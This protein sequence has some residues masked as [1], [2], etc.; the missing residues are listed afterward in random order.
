MI[1]K[2]QFFKNVDNLPKLI[3]SGKQHKKYIITQRIGSTCYGF[4]ESESQFNVDLESLYQA[5]QDN[6]IVNTNT[7][8]HGG[9]VTGRWRSPSIAI[10]QNAGLIDEKGNTIK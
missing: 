4:I 2:E 10:M 9:Y 1:S 5:Y 6:D 7:L 3:F 8:L